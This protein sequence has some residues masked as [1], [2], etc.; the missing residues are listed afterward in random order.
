MKYLGKINNK[1][2]ISTACFYP[3]LLE[4]AFDCICALNVKVCEIFIN[5][6]SEANPKFLK[7]I[8]SKADDNGVKI[9]AVHPFFSGYEEFLFMSEYKRRTLDSIDL[10]R[11]FFEAARYLQS[12]YVIFHGTAKSRIDFTPEK[13]AETFMLINEE[14]KKYGAELLQEN[15]ASLNFRGYS[16]KLEDKSENFIKSLCR[17][18]PGIRFTLD[19]KH[20][21][22]GGCNISDAIDIMGKNI[23]HIHFNDMYFTDDTDD[24]DNNDNIDDIDESSGKSETPQTATRSSCRLPFFGNLNYFEIF[25]KLSGINYIGSFIIEVYRNNYENYDRIAES[26]KKFKLFLDKIL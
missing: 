9:A 21:L 6:L 16:D 22:I 19:F 25:K 20:T 13:Y 12:D 3:M 2:G 24:T 18:E 4:G 23:A 7:D 14:A 17:T 8:K 1:I 11:H 5:T 15:V 10:Y 26:I